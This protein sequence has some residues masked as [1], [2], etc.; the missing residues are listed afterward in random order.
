MDIVICSGSVG[1]PRYLVRGFPVFDHLCCAAKVQNSF[2]GLK[3]DNLELK[4]LQPKEAA[5]LFLY[6]AMSQ[7]NS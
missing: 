5:Q 1:N 2:G 6:R 4:P 3:T 7:L